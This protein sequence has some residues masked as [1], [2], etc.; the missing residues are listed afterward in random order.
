MKMLHFVAAAGVTAGLAIVAIAFSI[1]AEYLK[2]GGSVVAIIAMAVIVA[3]PFAVPQ[4]VN[5]DSGAE[6]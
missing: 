2:G 3:L 4:W 5:H 1:P 6:E